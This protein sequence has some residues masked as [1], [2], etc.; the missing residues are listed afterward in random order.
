MLTQIAH[1]IVAIPF[2]YDLLQKVAGFDHIARLLRPHL[3]TTAGASLLDFGAGTGNFRALAPASARYIWFDSDPVKLNGYRS[4]YANG[5]SVLGHGGQL[6]FADTSIDFGLFI[7]VSHH[8]DNSQFD[9]ALA[10]LAAI[11]RRQLIFFDFYLSEGRP[12][13]DLLARFDR[14]RHPRTRQQILEFVARHF[15]IETIEDLSVYHRY[16]LVIA[17]PKPAYAQQNDRTASITAA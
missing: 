7:S 9:A 13:S 4:K 1:R 2:V 3:Q 6:C 8:L 16:V 12:I 14:G 5:L 17:N 11:L 15:D 10:S